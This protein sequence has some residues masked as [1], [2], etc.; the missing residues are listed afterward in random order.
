M[1]KN[2]L[3]IIAILSLVAIVFIGWQYHT[4]RIKKLQ[5]SNL[6]ALNDTVS[7]YKT[8]IAGIE[9]FVAERDALILTQKE[10]IKAG[11]LEKET[12]KKLNIK[13]LSEITRLKATLEV[14]RDSVQ[15]TGQIVVVKDTAWLLPKNAILL[16]FP[17]SDSTKYIF[18]KGRFNENGVMS[19][20]FLSKI[21]LDLYVGYDKRKLKAVVTTNNPYINIGE[22]L[23]IKTDIKPPKKFHVGA[24]IGY[25]ASE[26]GLS[27]FFGVGVGY[28][29][30]SF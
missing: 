30:F 12:L 7:H 17:F 15:H 19:Y 8:K 28:S 20:A 24:F 4:T 14:V 23:S 21:D 18:L 1:S 25:G 10:A 9:T 22:I 6:S 27:P 13:Q 26:Q 29:L 11:F 2:T 16:P 3:K 5:I